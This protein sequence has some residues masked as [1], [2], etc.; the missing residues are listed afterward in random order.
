VKLD[1]VPVAE[2]AQPLWDSVGQLTVGAPELRE[3][4]RVTAPEGP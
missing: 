3:W 4:Q 2:R 1:A